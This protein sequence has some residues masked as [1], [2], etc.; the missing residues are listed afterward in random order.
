MEGWRDH[1]KKEGKERE[2]RRRKVGSEKGRERERRRRER[3]KGG[4]E[5]EEGR[6]ENER[7]GDL[8]G[9]FKPCLCFQSH[10]TIVC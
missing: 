8:R 1:E 3:D 5:K 4:G 9:T 6:W 2:G 7:E 10:Q